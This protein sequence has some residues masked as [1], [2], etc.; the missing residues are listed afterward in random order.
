MGSFLKGK[1]MKKHLLLT[2]TLNAI[3]LTLINPNPNCNW[4]FFAINKAM[5]CVN[6]GYRSHVEMEPG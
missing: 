1:V 5:T 2:L 6:V 4:Y 3:T